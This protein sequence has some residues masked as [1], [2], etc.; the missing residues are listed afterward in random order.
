M[1]STIR[2]W[3]VRELDGG[4]HR[5]D[6][7][8][9]YGRQSDSRRDIPIAGTSTGPAGLEQVQ[10]VIANDNTDVESTVNQFVTDYNSLVSA[11]NTQ[12]GNDSSGNPEPLFGSPTLS[13]LQQQLLSGVNT[14]N[15]NGY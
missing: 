3:I 12:E 8:L 14:V 9:E 4:R 2:V 1:S 15:P 10:V 13:L 6:Q 7:R 11:M 5:P